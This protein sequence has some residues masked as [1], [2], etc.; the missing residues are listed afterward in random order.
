[1]VEVGTSLFA[2][3]NVCMV[4]CSFLM[5]LV[6]V[7]WNLMSCWTVIPRSLAFSFRLSSVLLNLSSIGDGSGLSSSESSGGGGFGW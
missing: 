7:W 2:Y 6:M 1:M 3:L 4:G 5:R